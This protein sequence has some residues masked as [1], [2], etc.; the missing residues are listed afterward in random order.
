MKEFAELAED[1]VI[2]IPNLTMMEIRGATYAL[3]LFVN[4]WKNIQN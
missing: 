4:F 3:R 2:R 1:Q